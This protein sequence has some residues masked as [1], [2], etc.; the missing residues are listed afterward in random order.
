MTTPVYQRLQYRQ[1]HRGSGGGFG[2]TGTD[3]IMVVDSANVHA[4][5]LATLSCLSTAANEAPVKGV[6]DNDVA[7]ERGHSVSTALQSDEGRGEEG[8]GRVFH[9]GQIAILLFSRPI[10]VPFRRRCRL[11]CS[12]TWLANQ[13]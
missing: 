13:Q 8:G 6:V 7:P 5:L 10:A 3:G 2:G 9:R 1:T 12:L 4:R 11:S